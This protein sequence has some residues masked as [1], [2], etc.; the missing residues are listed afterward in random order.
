MI[1]KALFLILL[2]FISGLTYGQFFRGLDKSPM[3]VAYFPDNFAHDRKA[4]EKAV[5]KVTYS[6]PQR[7]GRE[8]FGKLIPYGEVWRTGA[9][10]ASEIRIYEPLLLNGQP[11]EPGIYSLFTI[12]EQDKWTIILN[13][14][15][16]YWGSYSYLQDHDVLR[17]EAPVIKID[18][19]VEAFTIQ[20]EATGEGTA[21]MQIAWGETLV[22]VPVQY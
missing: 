17:I 12:P 22:E 13:E 16:D 6:R 2:F 5:I 1:K 14:D 8:L 18:Q 10:E 20:F 4:G 9:N 3:D 21:K 11:V 15:L 7:K 19:N